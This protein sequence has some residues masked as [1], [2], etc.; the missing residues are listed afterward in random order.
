MFNPCT[1]L[2]TA[3]LLVLATTRFAFAQ[4]GKPVVQIQR[5][6]AELEEQANTMSSG[7]N[8]YAGNLGGQSQMDVRSYP[9]SA[10]CV[11]VFESGKYILEKKT[12][13]TIGS[14]K[15]KAAEGSLSPDDLQHLKAILNEPDVQKITMPKPLEM[16]PDTQAIRDAERVDVQVGRP[17]GTQQFTLTKERIKTGTSNGVS[18][19]A[20]LNGMDTYLDNGTPY[21]KTLAP[22][23][24]WYD[25]LAKKAKFTDSKPQ[26]CQ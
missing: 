4:D 19:S 14:P 24:K 3:G 8:V 25:D 7:R 20:S 10:N 21:K 1:R 11:I 5:V 23:M 15:F 18:S 13:H 2:F 9:N 12:E 6:R 16:P 26:Y 22:L 17:E